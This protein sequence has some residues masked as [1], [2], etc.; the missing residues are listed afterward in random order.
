[1]R[2]LRWR[3]VLALWLAAGPARAL[4]FKTG[5]TGWGGLYGQS[6]SNQTTREGDVFGLLG[7][8]GRHKLGPGVAF[9]G[10]AVTM[11]VLGAGGGSRSG[12]SYGLRVGVAFEHVTALVGGLVQVAPGS[13]TETSFLPSITVVAG[14]ETLRGVFGLFDRFGTTPLRL[15]VEYQQ[16]GLAYVPG[17]G[18]EGTAKFPLLP[19]LAIEGR[20]LAYQLLN[21]SAFSTT[22]GLQWTPGVTP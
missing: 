18:L 20:V 3:L 21:F 22:V 14:N 12:Q 16:F 9:E 11:P 13:P 17:L 10:W 6:L 19:D 1:M 2:P 4:D 7:L 15:G 5:M 8:E